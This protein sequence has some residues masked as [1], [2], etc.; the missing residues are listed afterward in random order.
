VLVVDAGDELSG[1]TVPPAQRRL[2]AHLILDVFDRFGVQAMALGERDHEAGPDL[3]LALAH[4]PQRARTRVAGIETGA[5]AL[6]LDA[7]PDGAAALRREAAAAKRS[8]AEL[9]VALLHGG[10]DKARQALRGAEPSG[11]TVAIVSHGFGPPAPEQVGGAWLAEC[12]PQGKQFCQLDLHV[13]DGK[14][15]FADAGPRA[16]IEALLAGEQQAIADITTRQA[17]SSPALHDFYERQKDQVKQQIADGEKAL[18][19]RAPSA[20]G[21]WLE[22]RQTPLGTEVPDLPAIAELVARYKSEV[23]K[24]PPSPPPPSGG[25]AGIDACRGCHAP[26]VAFWQ[27]TRHAR[28]WASLAKTHQQND[29]ACVHCHVTG[30]QV[31]LPDIQ[32]EACHGPSAPHIG[33]PRLKG[34]VIRDPAEPVCT[35]C[36]T[37]D[38]TGAWELAAFR[39]AILG[40]GHGAPVEKR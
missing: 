29:A 37:K 3:G 21:S 8:G 40:P 14:L 33:D 12:A 28:A 26:A 22:A 38:Q 20:T 34:L 39:K 4:I 10:L 6:D 17:A 31:A 18:A 35:A 36:H 19:T 2:R 9:V 11:V 27:R 15:E 16:Q 1:P 7:A 24:L 30:G 25:Y 5:F 23:A 32:C 13:L